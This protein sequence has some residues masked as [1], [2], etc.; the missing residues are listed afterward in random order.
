[1]KELGELLLTGSAVLAILIRNLG[2]AVVFKTK[3]R[4]NRLFDSNICARFDC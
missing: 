2:D 3:L 4:G 1:M